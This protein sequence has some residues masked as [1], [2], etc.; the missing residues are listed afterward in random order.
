MVKRHFGKQQDLELSAS[1]SVLHARLIA[2]QSDS[3]LERKWVKAKGRW[4]NQYRSQEW[5]DLAD[6]QAKHLYDFLKRGET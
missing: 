6:R 4:S 2:L 1:Q 3:E 5:L